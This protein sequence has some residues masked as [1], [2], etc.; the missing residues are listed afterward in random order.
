MKKEYITFV[1]RLDDLSQEAANEIA[2]SDLTP[3]Q[4]KYEYRCVKAIISSSVESL[5]D[6]DILW[7]R[8]ELGHLHPQPWAIKITADLN[9]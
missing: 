4:H 3:G 6:S 1:Q 2:V 9:K 8:F 5:P 7:I